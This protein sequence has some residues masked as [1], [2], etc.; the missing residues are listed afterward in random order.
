MKTIENCHKRSKFKMWTIAWTFSK[1]M[2]EGN[3]RKVGYLL[4]KQRNRAK[5]TCEMMVCTKTHYRVSSKM[6]W[7]SITVGSLL[8]APNLGRL[9][10]CI[11]PVTPRSSLRCNSIASRSWEKVKRRKVEGSGSVTLWPVQSL[12]RTLRSAIIRCLMTTGVASWRSRRK[13]AQ[14]SRP[15]QISAPKWWC[16]KSK[17]IRTP[18][19]I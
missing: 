19:P 7:K 8:W 15:F 1:P 2:V 4:Q 6:S 13:A 9:G 5:I 12:C 3:H 10:T 18:K 11:S 14:R 16:N 17:R